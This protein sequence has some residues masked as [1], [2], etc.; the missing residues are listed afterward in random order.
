VIHKLRSDKDIFLKFFYSNFES[1]NKTFFFFECVKMLMK[2]C[3]YEDQIKFRDR[4]EERE[5]KQK[6]AKT[7]QNNKKTEWSTK[8]S[9][10]IIIIII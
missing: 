1:L 9:T 2:C 8:S 6:N 3:R 7:F 4:D 10:T 5:E